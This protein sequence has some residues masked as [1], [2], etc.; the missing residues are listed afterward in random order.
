MSP[1]TS[2]KVLFDANNPPTELVVLPSKG[3][4]YPKS[5]PLHNVKRVPIRGMTVADEEVLL[6]MA[7]VKLGCT[8]IELLKRCVSIPG[9]KE[10]EEGQLLAGD[11]SALL[12]GIRINSYGSILDPKLKCPSCDHENQLNINLN[13]LSF[14]TL[15]LMPCV[16]YENEFE[17]VMPNSGHHVTFGF[18][19]LEQDR[20]ILAMLQDSEASVT[21]ISKKAYVTTVLRYAIKSVNGER[22]P[23][24][25]RKFTETLKLIDSQAFR[26]YLNSNE[27]TMLTGFPYSCVGC[28]FETQMSLPKDQQIFGV[29]PENRNDIVLEPHFI[30]AY[31]AGFTWSEYV[32]YPVAYR[33][34]FME[35][36][37][38]ELNRAAKDNSDIPSKAPQHN[39]AEVRALLGKSKPHASNAKM[40]RFT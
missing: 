37:Q 32:N 15:D 26:N 7:Y 31:Y 30:M 28:G 38:E 34:K 22:N 6:N 13:Q 5:H 24:I 8:T 4:V 23:A 20:D 36:I 12:Y 27:P 14:N 1:T 10:I 40:Q 18:L 35:R 17:F 19:T 16:E 9:F 21:Q 39:G 33:K 2:R 29:S 3:L 11:V 25:I